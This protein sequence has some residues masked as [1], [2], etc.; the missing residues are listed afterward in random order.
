MISIADN[1]EEPNGCSIKVCFWGEHAQNVEFKV[2]DIVAFRSLRISDFNGKS[3]NTSQETTLLINPNI[4]E[5]KKLTRWFKEIESLDILKSFTLDRNDM[6]KRSN[7]NVRLV[8]EIYSSLMTDASY[9]NGFFVLNCHVMYSNFKN[10]L[11]V[12]QDIKI[13]LYNF[14]YIKA[15]DKS[16]YI[17]CPDCHK[18][19]IMDRE[20]YPR[21]DS[22]SKV[23][24][25]PEQIYMLTAKVGDLSDSIFVN[26]YRNNAEPIMGGMTAEEYNKMRFEEGM[27]IEKFKEKIESNFYKQHSIL[28]KA[29]PEQ[30]MSDDVR[31]KFIGTKI[32]DYSFKKENWNLLDRLECYSAKPDIDNNFMF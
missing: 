10:M 23:V 31:F 11:I 14:L 6:E 27:T 24:E 22:C 4:K 29:K 28:L 30:H 12:Y 13:W 32:L 8:K 21:W 16:T 26:F 17:G 9:Q 3:L 19:I 20:N 5:T 18:K 2:G 1:S 25:N 7:E 15:D